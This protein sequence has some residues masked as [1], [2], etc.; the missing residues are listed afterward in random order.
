MALTLANDLTGLV[1]RE[2]DA[3]QRY[4]SLLGESLA[5]GT[6]KLVSVVDSFLGNSLRDNEIILGAIAK[7]TSYGVNLLQIT[8]E[9]LN[10]ITKSMQECIKII[11]S[12]GVLSDDKLNILQ[13]SLNDKV[14]FMKF[15]I[16]SA[17][18]DGK[19]LL[20]GDAS[21]IG[22]Q[23]GPSI[24]DTLTVSV[25]DFSKG[26]LFRTSIDVSINKTIAAITTDA[27]A[28]AKTNYYATAVDIADAKVKNNNFIHN[29]ILG[30]TTGTTSTAQHT[31]L[32]DVIFTNE[33]AASAAANAGAVAAVYAASKNAGTAAIGGNALVANAATTVQAVAIAEL[34]SLDSFITTSAINTTIGTTATNATL[35]DV[36]SLHTNASAALTVAAVAVVYAGSAD[37]GTIAIG[38]NILVTGAATMPAAVAAAEK[39][40]AQAVL[41]T[42]NVDEGVGN[43]AARKTLVDVVVTHTIASGAATAVAVGAIYAASSDAGTAAIGLNPLVTGAASA[44]AA[45]KAAEGL[46]VQALTVNAN[47]FA[48]F[49]NDLSAD[50]KAKLDLMAPVTTKAL[51]T[52]NGAG[53]TFKN[54]T[55]VQLT[56][57]FSINGGTAASTPLA[58]LS[59]ALT[60]TAQQVHITELAS[61]LQDDMKIN[62]TDKT[63]LAARSIALDVILTSLNK[64]REEQ[65]IITNQK[66]NV[67]DASD[68]LRATTNVT[69]KAANS[70]LKTDYVL[71][72]Q[73]YA[74]TLR[75]M[76]ASITALQAANKVPEAAQRLLDSL[77][78]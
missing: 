15:V 59:T 20:G 23:V 36:I 64:V 40:A 21:D 54:A 45:V 52:A 22:V 55:L 69:E 58:T 65:A 78:R 19:N 44:S 27:N 50:Q 31:T 34:I 2:V 39:L 9:Y 66:S 71:T 25:S 37:A 10:T 61:L 57:M 49:I 14:D 48:T 3:A 62:I 73:K 35:T 43:L 32:L 75:T 70:Y 18:F 5:T 38:G 28:V 74:E 46:A 16:D 53:V 56:Q 60:A 1:S 6:D 4:S 42:K 33:T 7:N 26:K 76:V 8:D 72:A 67:L 68:A 63:S 13:N 24:T 12:A 11:N 29:A 51:Q 30:S 41:A 77:T 47:Q 17:Q